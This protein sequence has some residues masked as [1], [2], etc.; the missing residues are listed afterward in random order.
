MFQVTKRAFECV[1]YSENIIFTS[2]GHFFCLVLKDDARHGRH[3]IQERD[4]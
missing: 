2:F 4:F 3:A 1:R